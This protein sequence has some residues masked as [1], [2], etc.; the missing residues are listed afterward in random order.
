MIRSALGESD[1]IATADDDW[2]RILP[3]L[4]EA[5]KLTDDQRPIGKRPIRLARPR[6]GLSVKREKI[7]GGWA[8]RLTGPDATDMLTAPPRIAPAAPAPTVV[9]NWRL[10]KVGTCC[11]FMA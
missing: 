1:A 6:P 2:R 10:S 9:K 11:L 7:S 3:Y 8:I 5:E 4:E